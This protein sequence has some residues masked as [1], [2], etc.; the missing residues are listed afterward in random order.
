MGD[1]KRRSSSAVTLARKP[2]QTCAVFIPVRTTSAKYVETCRK[3][4]ARTSGSWA[5]VINPTAE[6]ILVPTSPN[7]P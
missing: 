3:T 6:P 1:Q 7:F 5:M 2:S 4:P